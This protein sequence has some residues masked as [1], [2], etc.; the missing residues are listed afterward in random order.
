MKTDKWFLRFLMWL[1]SAI[2]DK[3]GAISWKRILALYSMYVFQQAG[4]DPSMS[5]D[6]LVVYASIPLLLMG[7][8]IPEWFSKSVMTGGTTSSKTT[9][10]KTTQTEEAKT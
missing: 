1:G 4:K 7:M 9:V 2:E 8:T 10:E 5:W 3:A 6:K